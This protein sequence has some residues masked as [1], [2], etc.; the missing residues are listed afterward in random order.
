MQDSEIFSYV[1][2]LR[3][4]VRDHEKWRTKTTLNLISSENFAS[5]ETRSY[6][7]TDLSNRYSARDHYYRGT[8]YADDIED[9]AMKVAKKLYRARFADVRAISGHTCSLIVF[10][11]L[12]HPENK[13]VTCP[14]E[15]GG[16]P[17]SSELGLGPLLSLKNLYFPYDPNKMNIIPDE[18]RSLLTSEKPEMTVFGSS[19]IPFP[20]KIKESLPDDYQGFRVYDGSHVMGLIAGGRFQDPLREGSSILMGSTHKSLFGP[21]GG[22]ILSNDEEVFSK[23]DAKVAPGIVDNIHWNRVAALTFAMIELLK[24][25]ERYAGQVIRNSKALAT[26]LD[27]LGIPVKSKNYGFTES[28]Q[29]I[30]NFDKERSVKVANL[31]QELD[32]ITDTGIRLGTSEVTRRGMKEKEMQKIADILSDAIKG[33]SSKAEIRRRVHKLTGEHNY[34]EFTLS[35]E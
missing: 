9:L 20:Y 27:E 10:M 35:R 15:Y 32:I 22:L 8:K 12:L 21:Q 28:H 14:P 31:L 19:Y 16:Y 2:Q 4:D 17:G 25:G 1:R 34:L 11:S 30:L 13:I 18:T 24:F 3:R 5:P 33:K 23:I 29:V 7:S 26:S 6:L